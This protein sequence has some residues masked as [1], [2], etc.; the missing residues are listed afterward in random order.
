MASSSRVTR[1]D[2]T[3]FDVLSRI[4]AIGVKTGIEVDVRRRSPARQQPCR[5]EPGPFPPFAVRMMRNLQR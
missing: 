4:G 2:V 1:F 5:P 3:R